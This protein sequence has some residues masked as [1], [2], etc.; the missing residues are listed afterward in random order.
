[1]LFVSLNG[2]YQLWI[3]LGV[4][5]AERLSRNIDWKS[6]AR[7]SLRSVSSFAWQD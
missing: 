1:M 7:N 5:E 4:E 6:M 3:L 2:K